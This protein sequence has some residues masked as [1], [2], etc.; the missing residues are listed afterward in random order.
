MKTF[1]CD[2]SVLRHNKRNCF[3]SYLDRYLTRN[4]CIAD[5]REARGRPIKYQGG[6]AGEKWRHFLEVS[7]VGVPSLHRFRL[8]G[9][10]GI[11]SMPL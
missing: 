5:S 1:L 2:E 3:P 9:N 11:L 8:Q 7:A 6:K 10:C 4:M